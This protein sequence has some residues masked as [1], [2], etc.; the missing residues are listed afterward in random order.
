MTPQLGMFHLVNRKISHIE[1]GLPPSPRMFTVDAAVV[2][3]GVV[4][5]FFQKKKLSNEDV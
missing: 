1:G 3:P 5:S 2:Q 4:A